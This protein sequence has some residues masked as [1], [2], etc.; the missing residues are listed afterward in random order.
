MSLSDLKQ[1][2]DQNSY[3]ALEDGGMEIELVKKP[4]SN[5]V[6]VLSDVSNRPSRTQ[7]N[8]NCSSKAPSLRHNMS[9]NG[10]RTSLPGAKQILSKTTVDK[11]NN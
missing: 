10:D 7:S 3:H 11:N 5:E 6:K 1:W 4:I 2:D 8:A 9:S